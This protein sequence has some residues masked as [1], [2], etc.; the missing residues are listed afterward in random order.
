MIAAECSIDT[1]GLTPMEGGDGEPGPAMST[2]IIS[3]L[4]R[5]ADA[6]ASADRVDGNRRSGMLS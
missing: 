4:W 3:Y 2:R 1:M 6:Q 5:T